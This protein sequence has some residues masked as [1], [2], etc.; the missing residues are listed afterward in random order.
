MSFS[1]VIADLEHLSTHYQTSL[2]RIEQVNLTLVCII[3][4]TSFDDLDGG[5]QLNL[6]VL[7]SRKV[8]K[9]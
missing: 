7:D 9:P 2:S 4:A 8:R 5:E 1:Q 6:G 3:W